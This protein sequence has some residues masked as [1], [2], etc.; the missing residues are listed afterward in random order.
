MN[1]NKKNKGF[2]IIELMIIVGVLGILIALGLPNLQD[3]LRRV[4]INSQAKT[5]LSSLNFTRSEAIKRG[6]VVA[7]C[8]SASGSDCAVD[9]WSA[10]WLV[11]VDNN[12]DA[13]G[14]SGSVDAGDEI[15]RVYQGLAGTT[16]SFDANLQQYD[17]RGFGANNALRSFLL[18]PDDAD[19][20]L[21]QAVEIAVTGRGRRIREGLVCP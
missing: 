3:T 1:N 19:S 10:G 14:A 8:A 4:G 18:C 9:T 15:L 13:D 2:T 7:V 12:G 11:F 20:A 5:L 21:A 6:T 16:L 17:A